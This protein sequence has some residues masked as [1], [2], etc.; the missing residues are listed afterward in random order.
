MR[1]SRIK[2][3]GKELKIINSRRKSF[4]HSLETILSNVE[5]AQLSI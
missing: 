3:T 2:K 5:N 4:G 1:Y